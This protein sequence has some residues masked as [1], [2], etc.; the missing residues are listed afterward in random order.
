MVAASWP[1]A[2]RP[3]LRLPRRFRTGSVDLTAG[4]ADWCSGAAGGGSGRTPVCL[5]GQ[6]G[7]HFTCRIT[8]SPSGQSPPALDSIAVAWVPLS[9]GASG[10]YSSQDMPSIAYQRLI[11]ALRRAFTGA[12]PALYAPDTITTY[13]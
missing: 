9:G 6:H 11:A 10:G 12:A 8:S 7:G 3:S 2:G 4:S 1:Q 5:G 13:K